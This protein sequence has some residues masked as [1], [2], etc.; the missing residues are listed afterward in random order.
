MCLVGIRVIVENLF[1]FF[2]YMQRLEKGDRPHFFGSLF[3][4]SRLL[5][6]IVK[7]NIEV[8]TNKH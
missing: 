3:S 5:Q 6:T 1:S 2:S 8:E 4:K 7:E